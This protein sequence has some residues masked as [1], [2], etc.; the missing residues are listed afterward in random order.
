MILTSLLTLFLFC[1]F[2]SD[3]PSSEDDGQTAAY[4]TGTLYLPAEAP[5]KTFVV[6]FDDNIDADDGFIKIEAGTCGDDTIQEYAID[7]M[8][9]GTYYL[10][11][12][13]WVTGPA[14]STPQ[15]GDYVGY[16][17]TEGTIP[18]EPNASVPESGS[19]EFDITLIV[20]P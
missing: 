20:L 1:T 5:G 11:A 3:N 19:K 9:A 12:V 10:Y 14:F 7:E 17:G 2:C 13:V 8:P 15:P 18:L 16:Y 4:I 6:A